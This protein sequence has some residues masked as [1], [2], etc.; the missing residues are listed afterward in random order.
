MISAY[1]REKVQEFSFCKD[2][3]ELYLSLK[4]EVSGG[5]MGPF[6]VKDFLPVFSALFPLPTVTIRDIPADDGSIS[7]DMSE[8]S[9]EQ[10]PCAP[11]GM[12]KPC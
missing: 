6:Q 9:V 12:G 7:L 11:D 5:D 10:R 2:S 1:R 3:S 4:L 8:A